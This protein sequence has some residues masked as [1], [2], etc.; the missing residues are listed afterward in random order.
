MKSWFQS[1]I[2]TGWFAHSIRTAVAAS[3]SLA[4]ARLFKMPQ[5][6]WAAVTTMIVTQSTLGAAWKIAR[7]R[8]IGT[9]IGATAGGLVA[10][11]FGPNALA[12]GLTIFALGIICGSL[13]LDPAAYRF[14]G[15]ALIIVT[16]VSAGIS[17]PATIAFH[18]FAEVAIGILVGLL[19]SAIWP[20]QELKST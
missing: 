2:S 9:A 14:A 1:L 10:T 11:F 13:K 7:R 19:F 15:V 4:F 17:P 3:V 5:P 20:T 18:R 6:Y 12:V 16:L 8:L